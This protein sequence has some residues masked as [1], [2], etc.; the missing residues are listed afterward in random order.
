MFSLLPPTWEPFWEHLDQ[1]LA[2][3]TV[4]IDRPHGAAHPRYPEMIYPLDYGYLQ[5]TTSVDGGGIDVW[6]GES[7]IQPPNAVIL[8][9]D[10]LKKD[11][12]LKIMLGCTPEEKQRVL[13]FLNGSSMRATLIERCP[14]ALNLL[15]SRHSVRRFL[16]QPIPEDRLRQVLEAVTWAPSAH[17]R[18]PWRL[19]VLT[20]PAARARLA[21]EL[22]MEFR[23]S[24][25]ADGLDPAA[26]EEQVQ[27]SCQRIQNAPA[28]ILFS[29]DISLGDIYLD[30]FRQQAE[31][32]MGVQGVAMAGQ[33]L[34]LAAQAAG[35]GAVWVCAPLFAPQAARRALDLPESWQA[36]GL[37]LLG[38]PAAAGRRRQRHQLDEI[39]HFY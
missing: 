36:Q 24:L 2:A 25:L 28:A 21:E 27:R 14:D 32:L 18:Q 11:A 29:L 6:V 13:D 33:N 16:P 20:S 7:G 3:S 1:L 17:N 10:L 35:L 5:G 37:V 31:L 19:S 38:Y 30:P 12:E 23:Q 4:V 26:A 39:A 22:G 8:T 34:L 9:V 15:H